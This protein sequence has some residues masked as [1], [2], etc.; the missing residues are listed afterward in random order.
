MEFKLN[1]AEQ[2]QKCADRIKNTEDVLGIQMPPLYKTFLTTYRVG[3]HREHFH[4]YLDDYLRPTPLCDIRIALSN[5]DVLFYNW[6]DSPLQLGTT[7]RY[8]DRA[9]E[10]LHSKD[11]LMIGDIV[12][13]GGLFV[14]IS[15]QNKDK[16]YSYVYEN[17]EEPTE[18][19]NSIYELANSIIIQQKPNS[20]LFHKSALQKYWIGEKT[21]YAVLDYLDIKLIELDRSQTFHDKHFFWE[22]LNNLLSNV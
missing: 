17:Q 13:T 7:L 21:N 10:L 18:I 3:Q 1:S 12:L 6:L 4:A 16:I 11:I 9:I 2:M 22:K 5:G 19:F 8:Y 20:N 14:G 15:D